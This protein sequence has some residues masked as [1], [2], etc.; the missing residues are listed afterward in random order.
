MILKLFHNGKIVKLQVIDKEDNSIKKEVIV[1]TPSAIRV[2]Y[3]IK[4]IHEEFKIT[5]TIH[6]EEGFNVSDLP[7]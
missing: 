5:N 6:E 1:K 7:I 4:K 3:Q 2:N